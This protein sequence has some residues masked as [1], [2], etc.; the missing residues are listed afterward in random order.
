MPAKKTDI[1]TI[2]S[3]NIVALDSKER[4]ELLR[5]IESERIEKIRAQ[6]NESRIFTSYKSLL[7]ELEKTKME[8]LSFKSKDVNSKSVN[9]VFKYRSMITISSANDSCRCVE[10]EGQNGNVLISCNR[11]DQGKNGILKINLMDFDC[12]EFIPLHSNSIRSVQV[13]PFKDQ[14]LLTAGSDKYLK[15]SN[16]YHNTSILSYAFDSPVWSCCFHETNQNLIFCGTSNGSI[17]ECDIRNTKHPVRNFADIINSR[18]PVH[19]IYSIQEPLLH[20][21]LYANFNSPYFLDISDNTSRSFLSCEGSCT[22]FYYERKIGQ[23][24]GGFRNLTENKSSFEVG[25]V[26][27]VSPFEK[28]ANW[29]CQGYQKTLSKSSLFSAA[30]GKTFALI[31]NECTTELEIWDWQTSSPRIFMKIPTNSDWPIMDSTTFS[32]CNKSYLAFINS[33]QGFFYD[34]LVE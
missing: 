23:Y 27:S 20:G 22:F 32:K 21:L 14:L 4:E 2:F 25:A 13:S 12:L 10:F 17:Y 15:L 26:T 24:I 9:W 7:E 28:L 19:S 34:I 18:L 33:R 6:E 11:G 1:R 3:R 16:I 8:L 29:E 31:P 30:P 5:Q